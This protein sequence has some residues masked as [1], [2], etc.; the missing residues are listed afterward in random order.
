MRIAVTAQEAKPLLVDLL[1]RGGVAIIPC[2]TVYGIVGRVPDTEARIRSI[3][4]REETNPFLM[5]IGSVDQL[6]LISDV[7]LDP[8]LERLWPGPVTLV[9]PAGGRTVAVRLPDDAFLRE[10]IVS[11]SAPIYS[12][13]VN[14]SGS[15]PLEEVQRIVDLFE[16]DVD[17]I[18]DGGNLFGRRP[19]TILDVSSRPF[20]V[21]R[22][23]AAR[24]PPELLV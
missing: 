12:T 3:K 4:G 6:R 1:A 16:S 9:I 13:S 20:R 15:P 10:V 17:L 14:R 5:L 21:L 22:E 24:I 18:L 2:D 19:S 8:D 11:L 7:K 23:G